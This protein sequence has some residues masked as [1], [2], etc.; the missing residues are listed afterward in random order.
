ML[1]KEIKPGAIVNFNEAP[2]LIEAV[3]VQSPTARGA[4]TFYKYKARNLITKQKVDITLRGGEMLDEADFHKRNIKFM[5]ADA[6]HIHFLDQADYNQY[7]LPKEDLAEEVQFLTEELEGIQAL[8]Y[9]DE[10]VGIQLP[11]AVE[12]TVVECDPAIRGASA[13]SRTK[14]AKLE[15]GVVIQVPEYLT[16]GEK[17]KVDTR[18]GTYLSRA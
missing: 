11:V 13:T 10:C 12:L 18:T 1:A 7:S 17:I 3:N 8:I 4:A 15:T 2:C 14:S 6:T 5:Y 9:N 16:A